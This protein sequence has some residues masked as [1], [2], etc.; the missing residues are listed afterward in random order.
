MAKILVVG[1]SG[2]LGGTITRRALAEGHGVWTISRGRTKVPAGASALIADRKD[3]VA[4][5]EAIAGA[6]TCWDLVVDSAAFE[7][8]DI[9][10]D[11]AVLSGLAGRLVFVSTDFVYDPARRTVPQ[12][13]DAEF[14]LA[15]GYGGQK[16]AA[17][18][19]LT[20]ARTGTMTWSIVR[21][22]HIYGPGSQ[23]GCLPL[24][25]RDPELIRRLRAGEPLRLVGG[26]HFLQQ[27]VLAEDLASTILSVG[28][29]EAAAG[30]IFNVAGPEI[31]ESCE[32]YRLIA[33]IL[34]AAL[35]IEEVPVGAYLREKPES[36]PF[37]CHRVYDLNA[38]RAVSA[39]LPQTPLKHGLCSH[40]ARLIG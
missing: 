33:D 39:N 27:P 10:Q 2:F 32:Y 3:S 38:L 37:L 34:G 1:G 25:G 9:H 26:G 15:G 8:E 35:T 23:L 5:A 18:V 31:I 13:E 21:P 14:Y 24:H 19:A 36:A 17:E 28:E 40:V 29:K 12:A 7:S 11:V 6:Q 20:E 4:F 22:T 16:R 30:K